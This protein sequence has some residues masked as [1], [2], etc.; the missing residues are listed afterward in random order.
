MNNFKEI[1]SQTISK[2]PTEEFE[3]RTFSLKKFIKNE[4]L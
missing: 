1:F 4:Y 3:K 2:L